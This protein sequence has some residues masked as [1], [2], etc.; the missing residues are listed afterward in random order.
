MHQQASTSL[1]QRKLKL[2]YIRAGRIMDQ[3]EGAGIVGPFEGSVAREV[4]LPDEYALDEF[5]DTLS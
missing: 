2:G 4:L 5:L 1:I 3:L